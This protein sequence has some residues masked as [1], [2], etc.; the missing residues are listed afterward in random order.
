MSKKKIFTFLKSLANNNS[1]EWMDANR[2]KY[3]EA[4]D[5]W[6]NEIQLILDRLSKYNSAFEQVHP[7][8]TITRINNNRR[9]HP[10][11]PI[12]KDFFSCSPQLGD[13]VVGF[14]IQ[15]SQE[16]SMIGGGTWRPEAAV[17]RKIRDGIDYD[18]DELLDI[19]NAAPFQKV[20]GGLTHDDQMLKT[21]P[22]GFDQDH[23][24]IDLLRRKS[25][26][27]IQMLTPADVIS[28]SYID[29]IEEAYVSLQPLNEWLKKVIEFEE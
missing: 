22:R 12:Y 11:K 6:L 23:K 26:T 21:S 4:K 27:G 17:L 16:R 25:F 19:I 15:V 13:W 3:Q 10:N 5:I 2:P 24:H 18:G 1:K 29:T 9:F 7:K 20:F 28:D 14:Y 8:Q